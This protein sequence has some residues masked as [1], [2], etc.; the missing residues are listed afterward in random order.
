M[1]DTET[2]LL[3][4]NDRV[5]N[6]PRLPVLVYARVIP[7]GDDPA[8]AFERLFGGNGWPAR[9]RDG[10]YDYHHYHSTAHEAL[11]IAAGEATLEIG[12]PGGRQLDV[13]PGD[14]LVLPAGTGHRRISASDDFLVV[15][16]Y[17][18]GQDFDICR[19]A[20]SDAMLTRI[21]TLPYPASDPVEGDGGGAAAGVQ[22]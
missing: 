16:A 15:G 20:P 9:W 21:A 8:A 3:E 1:T 2:L 11:G 5:P 22:A 4:R 18:P 6:N 12:G 14:A 17:P 13:G 7:P 19:T 10:I